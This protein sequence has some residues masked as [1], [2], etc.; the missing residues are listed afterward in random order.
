VAPVTGYLKPPGGPAIQEFITLGAKNWMVLRGGKNPE[1]SKQTILHF[2][3]DLGRYDEM[4]ASSPAYALP[5][6]TDL[7]DMSD[8]I[9]TDDVALQQK[10]ASLDV[11]GISAG[12][13]P[14][15]PSAAMVALDESGAWND[16]INSILTGTP[17]EEAVATAHERMV[18]I[19]QEFGLPGQQA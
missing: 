1:A 4:L 7:W 12:I 14:G 10:S 16:M 2:N 8:Y 15:P 11:S 5:C 3:A 13:Y 19:F 6:Y 9:Q 17:T 18:L